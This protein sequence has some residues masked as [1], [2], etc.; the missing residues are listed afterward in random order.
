MCT[1]HDKNIEIRSIAE[2]A[3]DLLPERSWKDKFEWFG[4]WKECLQRMNYTWRKGT[5]SKFALPDGTHEENEL[6]FHHQIVEK[7]ECYDITD[8][9]IFSF[10]RTPSKY[11]PVASTALV[12]RNSKQV[13]LE[14][15][16]D[17]RSITA[18]FTITMDW[19]FL[20][21]PLIYGGKT[22]QSLPRSQFAKDFSLIVQ[23]TRATKRNRWS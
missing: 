8:S 10:D 21:T 1:W 15:S 13:F 9:I 23:S 17:K 11:V 19:K 2:S 20:G 18:T 12:K 7:V 4:V 14:G 22:N 6:L 3:A 16:D 5:T